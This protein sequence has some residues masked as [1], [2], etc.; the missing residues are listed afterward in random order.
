MPFDKATHCELRFH[1][2]ATSQGIPY[3]AW[4]RTLITT[5]ERRFPDLP[6]STYPNTF[7]VWVRAN[8][9]AMLA[10]SDTSPVMN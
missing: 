6:V 3:W 9:N 1:H 5:C 7:L 8:T 10:I 2:A 4:I